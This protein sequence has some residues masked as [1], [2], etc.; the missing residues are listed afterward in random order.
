MECLPQRCCNQ[1]IIKPKQTNPNQKK[2]PSKQKN[3]GKL[4]IATFFFK[5]LTEL[6]YE[7]YYLHNSSCNPHYREP[8]YFRDGICQLLLG[9][10]CSPALLVPH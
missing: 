5:T 7:I 3:L 4:K 10:F 2:I 6:N 8:L 9:A 1:I